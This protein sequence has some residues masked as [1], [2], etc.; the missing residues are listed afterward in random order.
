MIEEII[1]L[2]EECEDFKNRG[3]SL[4]RE[5]QMEMQTYAKIVE[6]VK[7]YTKKESKCE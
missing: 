6:L 2:V 4:Y 5:E 1:R 3:E 7:E